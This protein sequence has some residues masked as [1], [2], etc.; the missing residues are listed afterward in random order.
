MISM[1]NQASC[2]IKTRLYHIGFPERFQYYPEDMP[3][4]ILDQLHE[5]ALEVMRYPNEIAAADHLERC[6]IALNDYLVMG[7]MGYLKD[8]L[9]DLAGDYDNFCDSSHTRKCYG[10]FAFV[11]NRK[12]AA[13]N[14]G[15]FPSSEAFSA[16]ARELI[17]PCWDKADYSRE[18][19]A[20]NRGIRTP[21]R[22]EVQGVAEA[23]PAEAQVFNG[24]GDHCAIQYVSDVNAALNAAV[25]YAAS[26]KSASVR[27]AMDSILT[28]D[29][30]YD[31]WII[32][33][34]T[35]R[36]A[37][38]RSKK[39][40]AERKPEPDASKPG[41]SKNR[42]G[43]ADGGG[44]GRRTAARP[45]EKP[46]GKVTIEIILHFYRAQGAIR[47]EWA[48]VRNLVENLFPLS[49]ETTEYGDGVDLKAYGETPAG[50][51]RENGADTY[52]EEFIRMIAEE[53]RRKQQKKQL[54]FV[55]VDRL[56]CDIDA[57]STGDGPRRNLLDE[58]I[59]RSM[60]AG[61][62][63]LKE[64]A[65][66]FGFSQPEDDPGQESAPPT[67]DGWNPGKDTPLPQFPQLDRKLNPN[68]IW[69]KKDDEEADDSPYKW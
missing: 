21:Y 17:L 4:E 37:I 44:T 47:E 30:A 53:I 7:V 61:V 49:W 41:R 29:T 55:D 59:G 11:W 46:A 64:L 10:F 45:E 6:V 14:P 5:K 23:A 48:F 43:D 16:L 20:M 9:P 35:P 40:E 57:V 51:W 56:E 31:H 50:E 34:P 52:S 65:G 60:R 69:E 8:L 32:H 2:L 36:E 12:D 27:T 19:E 67:R 54:L 38:V 28:E 63:V 3:P 68:K 13:L 66:V 33:S 15:A 18:G 39:R 24:D 62:E 1:Q 58:S 25:R 26:A 42:T 22:F